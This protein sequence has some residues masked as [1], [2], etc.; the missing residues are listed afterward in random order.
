MPQLYLPDLPTCRISKVL[1]R[2][3]WGNETPFSIDISIRPKVK[4][5]ETEAEYDLIQTYTVVVS[6]IV[7]HALQRA[8]SI[9]LSLAY[10]RVKRVIGFG[11]A[12]SAV[13]IGAFAWASKPPSVD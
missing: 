13:G 11:A 8:S 6:Q 3:S 7:T 10:D 5:V 12:I 9:Q 4:F 1:M 2:K